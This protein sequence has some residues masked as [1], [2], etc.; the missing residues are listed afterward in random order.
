M[1]Y[2]ADDR[3]RGYLLGKNRQGDS[4]R[5]NLMSLSIA[6]VRCDQ[7]LFHSHIEIA[8][9]AGEMKHKAKMTEGNS[10][11]INQRQY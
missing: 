3:Q 2:D 11:A 10:L 8:E 5:F 9:I 7:N 4:M 1:P 6:V